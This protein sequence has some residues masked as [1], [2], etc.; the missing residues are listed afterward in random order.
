M[1]FRGCAPASRCRGCLSRYT[2]RVAIANSRLIAADTNFVTFRWKDYR[3]KGRDR[4]KVMHLATGEFI[5][6]FLLHVLPTGFH[7]IRHYGLFAN[8]ARVRNIETIRRLLHAESPA[9]GLDGN[10]AQAPDAAD[11]H[12]L[13]Q[14]CPCCGGPMIIIETFERGQMPRARAPPA[15]RAA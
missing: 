3:T 2:H 1:R 14:P 15:R 6:R 10:I 11:T 9:A 7:R 13:R 5:R 4:Q 8:V 12:T